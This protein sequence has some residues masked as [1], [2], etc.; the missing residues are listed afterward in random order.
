MG[1]L[2][3]MMKKM[4]GITDIKQEMKAES[5]KMM[6]KQEE[7]ITG[8]RQEIAN[9]KIN[10]ENES[11]KMMK[12]MDDESRKN[13]ERSLKQDTDINNIK[14]G[15]KAESEKNDVRMTEIK[16]ELRNEIRNI[17][18]Q[19]DI[20]LS[21]MV[22]Q[23]E[24]QEEIKQEIINNVDS[25]ETKEPSNKENE[26]IQEEEV[27][28]EDLDEEVEVSGTENKVEVNNDENVVILEIEGQIEWHD[29]MYMCIALLYQGGESYEEVID[30]SKVE[31]GVSTGNRVGGVSKGEHGIENSEEVWGTSMG[32]QRCGF[33]GG[34]K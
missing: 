30:F 32:W 12:K 26:S 16:N 13:D 14:R 3:M 24:E 5:E 28:N 18:K 8:I 29:D 9:M 19:G 34:R 27:T 10:S 4:E 31:V 25:N 7:G 15:M 20:F 6:K 17:N 21:E 33:K 2:K 23:R 11:K 1:M 22:T